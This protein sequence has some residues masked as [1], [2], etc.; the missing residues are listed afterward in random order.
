M[1][2]EVNEG[3]SLDDKMP[4]VSRAHVSKKMPGR[5]RC[6]G[7]VLKE[8]GSRSKRQRINHNLD[9]NLDVSAPINVTVHLPNQDPTVR[10]NDDTHVPPQA[11]DIT[12]LR[13]KVQNST[14]RNEKLTQLVAELENEVR[15]LKRH[16]KESYPARGSQS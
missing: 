14:V 4:V 9:V 10:E 11:D 6:F 2:V 3:E 12:Q 15:D 7:R 1:F 13:R 16:A 8:E 5:S